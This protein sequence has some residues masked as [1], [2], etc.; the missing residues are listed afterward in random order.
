M[1]VTI[2]K[3]HNVA[4]LTLPAITIGAE[5]HTPVDMDGAIVQNDDVVNHRVVLSL[6]IHTAYL[7][8]PHDQTETVEIIDALINKLK[9]NMSLDTYRMMDFDVAE[10]RAEF[11]DSATRGALVLVAYHTIETYSQ[12]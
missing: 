1:A 9:T 10:P 7:N 11:A 12:E 3:S 2:Y 8:A 4:N 6:R 5:S